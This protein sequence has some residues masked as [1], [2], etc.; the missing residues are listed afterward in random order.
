ML[1]SHTAAP[2]YEP[3]AF[4]CCFHRLRTQS[5]FLNKTLFHTYITLHLIIDVTR[6]DRT[7]NDL[8]CQ[9]CMQPRN[10]KSPNSLRKN[11]YSID[12]DSENAVILE[13]FRFH[14]K[15]TF[16]TIKFPCLV[17]FQQ[18]LQIESKIN[19]F[20]SLYLRYIFGIQFGSIVIIYEF[21]Q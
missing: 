10:H 2:L 9:C 14:L 19:N 16:C 13:P 8:L 4:L 21:Y 18:S 11:W 3:F 7:K 1:L 5:F 12:R 15:I 6:I 20:P 17:S